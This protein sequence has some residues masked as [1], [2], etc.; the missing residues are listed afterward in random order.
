VLTVVPAIEITARTA[1]ITVFI[2][3]R[4][5]DRENAEATLYKI[6]SPVQFCI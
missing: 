5:I 2:L 1:P 4:M 6:E 3:N